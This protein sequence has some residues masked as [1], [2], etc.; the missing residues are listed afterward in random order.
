MAVYTVHEPPRRFD[1]E[2][3]HT[4]R[5]VFVRDGFHGWAF[6]FGPAWML[7]HRLWLAFV[8]WL[9]VAGGLGALL[10]AVRAGGWSVLVAFTV[11]GLLVGAEASSLRRAKLRRAGYAKVAV[12]IGDDLQ[13]AEHRFFAG[14]STRRAEGRPGSPAVPAPQAGPAARPG[15][16]G[17]GIVGLF[18][19]PGARA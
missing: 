7:R 2:L 12:V 16:A 8:G 19:E 13:A 1:D 15:S 10:A 17:S 5:F 14:W 9:V 11:L 4:S 6:L 18:P 3:A